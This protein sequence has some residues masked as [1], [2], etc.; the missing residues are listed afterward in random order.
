[1]HTAYTNCGWRSVVYLGQDQKAHHA[2]TAEDQ[3]FEG[4]RGVER[5]SG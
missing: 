4:L 5:L 3:V 2:M 1:M